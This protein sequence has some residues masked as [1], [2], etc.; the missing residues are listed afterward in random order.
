MMRLLRERERI[1][2]RVLGALRC[3]DA[4][5]LAPLD[6]QLEIRAQGLRLARNRSG[7]Y[8]IRSGQPLAAHE[9]AFEN[10]PLAP[11]LESAA[12][13]LDVRDP[14]GRYLSRRVRIALPR[15]PAPE[16]A[17]DP[18]SI[19]RAVD[20]PM[21]PSSVAPLGANW[22]ALRV[23]VTAAANADALG[24]ALIR[25][26]AGTDI[27]ARGLTDW[28]GEALVPV[29]GVPVTTWSTAPGAVVVTEIAATLECFF[30]S[31][32]GTRTPRA[33]VL[34]GVVPPTPALPDPQAIE[35]AR[36]G[37][38]QSSAAIVLAAA[39]PLSVVMTVA[40]P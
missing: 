19:F 22:V 21:Y 16:R 36:A 12:L 9:A 24:G 25:V 37:L 31:T 18:S 3:V 15:D 11:P 7:L 17:A 27:L 26:V 30:D 33:D 32:Q 8:V 23:S 34:A 14:S 20:I 29:A 35:A 2:Q 38:P 1:E 13:E 39:R 5:T 40:V 28:R 6:S 10:P 4:T